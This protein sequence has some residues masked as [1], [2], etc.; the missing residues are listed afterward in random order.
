M[1]ALCGKNTP[2]PQDLCLDPKKITRIPGPPLTS[3]GLVCK[4]LEVDFVYWKR[5]FKRK[6]T[7][8]ETIRC[9]KIK[10]LIYSSEVH[11]MNV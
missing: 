8:K 11:S 4:D 2:V 10:L 3:F 9:M 1:P 6:Q 7:E 5:H